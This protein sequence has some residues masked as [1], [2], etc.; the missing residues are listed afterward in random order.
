MTVP[1][2]ITESRQFLQNLLNAAVK[3]ALPLHNIAAYLP[4]PPKPG[5]GRTIVIG[6]GKVGASMAQAV[7]AL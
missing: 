3:R 5:Q 7:E 6:A 1:N 4:T 2:Y